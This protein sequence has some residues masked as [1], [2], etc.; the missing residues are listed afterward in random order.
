MITVKVVAHIHGLNLQVAEA[1]NCKFKSI[2]NYIARSRPAPEVHSET[3][4]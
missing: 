1:E 3:Y 4:S 2:T